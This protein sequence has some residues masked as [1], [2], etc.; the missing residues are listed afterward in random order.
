M[1]KKESERIK[2][3]YEKAVSAL[4]QASAQL[5]SKNELQGLQQQG[6][7]AARLVDPVSD[8]TFSKKPVIIHSPLKKELSNEHNMSIREILDGKQNEKIRAIYS[9]TDQILDEILQH[10]QEIKKL[11]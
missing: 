5:N 7:L 3:N 4:K 11:E 6:L 9:K 1:Q 8:K 2:R 10:K